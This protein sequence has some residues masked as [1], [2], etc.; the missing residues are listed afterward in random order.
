MQSYFRELSRIKE[1]LMENPEGMT[2]ADISRKLEVNRN[3]AAKYLDILLGSGQ[4]E[5]R[6]FGPVKVYTLSQRVTISSLLNLSNESIM[7]FN[8]DMEVRQLNEPAVQSLKGEQD[9]QL[10]EY[11]G[12]NI[13]TI[14]KQSDLDLFTSPGVLSSLKRGVEG[15]EFIGEVQITGDSSVETYSLKIIPTVFEDGSHGVAVVFRGIT[16]VVRST[17]ADHDMEVHFPVIMDNMVEGIAVVQDGYIKFI[18]NALTHMSGHE[19]E[20]LIG[21]AWKVLFEE[22]YWM[23]AKD[24]DTGDPEPGRPYWSTGC[25]LKTHEGESV[26][27]KLKSLTINYSNEEAHLL[28]LWAPRRDIS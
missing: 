5:M 10:E 8:R 22:E 2:I 9:L 27:V 23:S 18:N 16:N 12:M 20:E 14:S 19:K 4:L 15:I 24:S 26:I 25:V 11:L 6:P 21:K 13:E 17:G 1:I 3:S 28:F 7:I